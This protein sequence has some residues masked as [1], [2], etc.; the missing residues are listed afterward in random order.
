MPITNAGSLAG[1][2]SDPA[3]D[4]PSFYIPVPGGPGGSLTYAF[5]SGD[6]QGY[7]IAVQPDGKLLV[8][9]YGDNGN[10]T[11]MVLIRLNADGTLDTA[12][13]AAANVDGAVTLAFGPGHDEGLAVTV[14][15]DGKI[16]VAGTSNGAF[17]LARLHADGTPDAGFSGDGRLVTDFGAGPDYANALVLQ[18]DGKILVGGD[19][20]GSF[21][22]AR[23]NADGSLDAGFG[24]GGK[25]TTFAAQENGGAWSV[26]LQPDGKILLA[27]SAG[28]A[29]AVARYLSDG[30]PDT[31]FDGDGSR[32]VDF[33]ADTDAVA[34]SMALQPDGKVVLAGVAWTGNAYEMSVARLNP[35]GGLD[36][37]FEGDGKAMVS[38]GT[39]DGSTGFHVL[40]QPD[41]RIV[42]TGDASVEGDYDLAMIRLHANGTLD[43]SF[44]GDGKVLLPVGDGEDTGYF[45]TR[46]ADGAIVA[47]GTAT[48]SHGKELLV[49]RINA[50]GSPDS[51]FNGPAT[52]PPAT[53]GGAV[54]FAQHTAGVVLDADVTVFDHELAAQG[55]YG[56]ARLVL[57]R[58]GGAVA[59][60]IFLPAVGS[61]LGAFTQGGALTLGGLVVGT[62]VSSDGGLLELAF[63]ANATPER[64]DQALQQIA[65]SNYTAAPGTVQIG[66]AFSDGNSGAQGSG[67]ARSALGTV[68]VTIVAPGVNTLT[69]TDAAEA[70]GGTPWADIITGL[71]GNDS[72]TGGAGDDLLDGGGGS[73]H[74]W[75]SGTRAQYAVSGTASGWHVQDTVS[76]RD[77]SDAVSNI[78]FL[79]FSDRYADLDLRAL[80]MQ[81]DPADLK[82]M[83]E[84]YVGFFNRIPEADGM[85]FWIQELQAGR[86]LA[87]IADRFYEAGVAFGIY[88]ADFSDSAFVAQ[89]YDHVLARGPGSANPPPPH[90]IAFWATQLAAG[91]HTEGSLV[92]RMLSDV[93]TFFEDLPPGDPNFAFNFVAD[94]LNNKAAVAHHYA[95]ELGL[96]MYT[97]AQNI[98]FGSD[99][100]DLITPGDISAAWDLI[101]IGST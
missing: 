61:A 62:V 3:N 34:Y 55:H 42:V 39:W 54:I 79:H 53:L 13:G 58:A 38:A 36:T 78:G 60:D 74:A 100:V 17:A 97:P 11:D 26:A 23:Y 46:Q 10:D 65:Y 81:V 5:T 98:S 69:G 92:L 30:T 76:G 82:T 72:L 52:Q 33:N 28:H 90:D 32:T 94:L 14:Q 9:A 20:G 22:L 37:S 99:L 27:G 57:A 85:R 83:E 59:G 84:L 71:G 48:T 40:V 66:W 96:S 49:V 67:G 21:A 43:T 77:G 44:D 6:I 87:S 31:S 70:L 80:A 7:G 93:H 95:V 15:P 35:D 86:T 89:A 12:F 101:G 45:A 47:V 41:G 75:F 8:A 18:P 88:S 91:T 73:D 16:V 1:L 51:G 24:A 29:F 25:L 50:D 64:V 2:A 4:T 56:G 68:T 63:N 19:A